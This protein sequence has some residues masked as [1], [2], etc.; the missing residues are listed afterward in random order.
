M[1]QAIITRRDEFNNRDKS[2]HKRERAKKKKERKK[3]RMEGSNAT[4][5]SKYVI[6]VRIGVE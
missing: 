4:G 5:F 2:T 1:Q 3:R 6:G